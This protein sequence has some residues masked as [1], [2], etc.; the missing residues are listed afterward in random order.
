MVSKLLSLLCMVQP[1]LILLSNRSLFE[2]HYTY[3]ISVS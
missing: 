1:T 3:T 2:D